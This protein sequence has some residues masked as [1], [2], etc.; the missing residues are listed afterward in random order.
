M[1]LP[2][3]GW[4]NCRRTSEYRTAIASAVRA[5]APAAA[6]TDTRPRMRVPSMV[7]KRAPTESMGEE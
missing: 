3:S 5:D 6:P 4:S 7:K 2:V 1:P